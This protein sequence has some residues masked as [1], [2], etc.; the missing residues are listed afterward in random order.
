MAVFLLIVGSLGTLSHPNTAE[1]NTVVASMIPYGSFYALS[2]APLSYTIMGEAAVG[3]V[4]EATIQLGTSLSVFCTFLTSF[5]M[6]YHLNA[7]YAALGAKSRVQLR[8]NLC[9]VCHLRIL[10]DP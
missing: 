6:P 9:R 3:T 10:W 7:P 4:R 1:S 8:V 5:T 2:W